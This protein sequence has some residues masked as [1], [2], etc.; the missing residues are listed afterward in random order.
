MTGDMEGRGGLPEIKLKR[1]DTTLDLSQKAKLQAVS[2]SVE[3]RGGVGKTDRA[4]EQKT[5]G[6]EGL[7]TQ[8]AGA[9]RLGETSAV[10]W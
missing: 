7:Y 2:V 10:A 3:C 1:T 8:A 5:G 4:K 9:S 6:T